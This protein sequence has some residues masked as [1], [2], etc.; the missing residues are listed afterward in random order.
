MI[1]LVQFDVVSTE[2]C[3]FGSHPEPQPVADVT[4]YTAL[5]PASP[6]LT[7]FEFTACM[8]SMLP[9]GCG[10]HVFAAGRQLPSLKVLCLGPAAVRGDTCWD[11]SCSDYFYYN[12]EYHD[13]ERFADPVACF[14]P[15]DVERLVSCCPGLE[16]LWLPGL[17]RAGVDVSALL[18][19]TALTGLFVGGDVWDDAVAVAVVAE[20]HGLQQLELRDA[21]R[22]TDQGLLAL[23]ALTN[24]TQLRML[25]CG[26]S[27]AL[28]SFHHEYYTPMR[29][30]LPNKKGDC[31]LLARVGGPVLCWCSA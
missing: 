27:E 10:C 2:E 20:M 18:R 28:P 24:L 15:G 23:S 1:N 31:C 25:H 12:H 13:E 6:Q 14:G 22:L 11:Q 3:V 16:R 9:V 21:P 7:H 29:G 5:L 4:R 30:P 17:V 8:T 19:L 26:L